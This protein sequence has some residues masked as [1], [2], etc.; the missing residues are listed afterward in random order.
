MNK[1]TANHQGEGHHLTIQT[2]GSPTDV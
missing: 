2:K 1:P